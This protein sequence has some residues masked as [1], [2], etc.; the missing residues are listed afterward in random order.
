MSKRIFP[1]WEKISSFKNPLSEEF[2]AFIQY[3]DEN[4]LKCIEIYV[5]PH[6]N[7]DQPDLCILNPIKGLMIYNEI[8]WQYAE[9][10][11]EIK[12]K[13]VFDRFSQTSRMT[14]MRIFTK[15]TNKGKEPIA[16]PVSLLNKGHD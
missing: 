14:D 2:L 10:E 12:Q 6:I 13:K 11:M 8:R 15:K 9:V 3:L 5:R 7:G 4:L 16:D 1:N